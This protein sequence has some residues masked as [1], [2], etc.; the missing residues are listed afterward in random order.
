LVK[1]FVIVLWYVSYGEYDQNIDKEID[2]LQL[3]I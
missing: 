1:C 2:H 3:T